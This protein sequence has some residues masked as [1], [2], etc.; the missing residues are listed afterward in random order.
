MFSLKVNNKCVV[1]VVGFEGFIAV[2][3]KS[4]FFWDITLYSLLKVNG[5]FGELQGRP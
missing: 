5:R 3:V 1:I 2:D 4:T